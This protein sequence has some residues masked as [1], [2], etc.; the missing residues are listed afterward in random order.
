MG[1]RGYDTLNWH[2]KHS[3]YIFVKIGDLHVGE[4][5]ELDR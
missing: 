4:C 1:E 3:E 5:K 2:T